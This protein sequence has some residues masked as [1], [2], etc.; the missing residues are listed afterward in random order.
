MYIIAMVAHIL[1][2]TADFFARAVLFVQI[3]TN[4]LLTELTWIAFECGEK[5]TFW[6]FAA[7]SD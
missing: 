5:R 4:A 7:Q 3:K 2:A 1:L 6:N